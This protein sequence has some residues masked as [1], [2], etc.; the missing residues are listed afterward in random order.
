MRLRNPPSG[1]TVA[2]ASFAGRQGNGLTGA[3]ITVDFAAGL[4]STG[5]SPSQVVDVDQNTQITLA[6]GPRHETLEGVLIVEFL[7][8]FTTAFPGSKTPGGN[9]LALAAGNGVT[10]L[11]NCYWDGATWFLTLRGAAFA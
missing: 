1:P 7:G 10:S 4:G 6:P 5:A 8:N 11:V 3:A 2:V 9:P